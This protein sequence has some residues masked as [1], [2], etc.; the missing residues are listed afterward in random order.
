MYTQ[1]D[2]IITNSTEP[3]PY[4]E[5]PTVPLSR[6]IST[7]WPLAASW[8]LMS[9]ESPLVSAIMARLAN[10]E[11]NLAAFGGIVNP[12]ALIIES[13]IIM[14]LAASTTLS[15]DW[16]SYQKMRRYMMSAGAFLTL[17]HI[18]I[19]FTP[20]YYV[21]TR[22]IIG[23]PE[24]IIEPARLGF[25]LML[26]WTWSIAYRRFNQGV[27]IRFGHSSVIG[28]GTGVR[29]GTEILVLAIGYSIHTLPGIVVGAGAIA[30]GVF[31]EAA[32][33]G[34]RVQPVLRN[35]LHAAPPVEQPLSARMFLAFY[36]PLM[37]TSLLSL[38]I[39]P[40]GSASL[41]RMPVALPSL[42]AWPVVHGL[43]F[44]LQSMGIAL[45]EVV[46]TF[47]EQPGAAATLRRFTFT[48]VAITTGLLL[49]IAATPLSTWWFGQ[50][51]A[52]S[53]DLTALAR[54]ALWL[55]LPMPA[56]SALQS[57]FQGA[58]LHSRRT[59]GITESVII[60]LL[61]VGSILAAG[62]AWGQITGIYVGMVAF[63]CGVSMQ[64]FWLF[65]R[66][67]AAIRSV[68]ARDAAP[69]PQA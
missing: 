61:T 11:V 58:I 68:H 19:A 3:K 22:N 53:P 63:A 46:V 40:T 21:V 18:I 35:E 8:L 52:L 45:N 39:E 34:W 23:A 12:L 47:L 54:T 43:I 65:V 24:Q 16:G 69:Q 7:W 49:L 27:L 26:P 5:K 25:M 33:I 14:L 20:L 31:S 67:R 57:W 56:M 64:T 13:P 15:K 62:I 44:M 36:L 42:A 66:S 59:R 48:L 51:S 2:M 41:S 32:Y 17:L 4:N 30:M 55:A 10:P 60:Y 38:L 37:L 6:I 29:L 28:L 1:A 9:A 50:V